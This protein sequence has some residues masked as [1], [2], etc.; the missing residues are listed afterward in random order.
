MLVLE[1]VHAQ[2]LFLLCQLASLVTHLFALAALGRHAGRLFVDGT[3]TFGC[4]AG[5]H[6]RRLQFDLS[7]ILGTV[8]RHRFAEM[9][10]SITVGPGVRL[11]GERRTGQ[12][13]KAED[14]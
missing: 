6:R 1:L 5:D 12:Q 2:L 9:G 4:G 3:K 7:G 11:S 8:G 10:H 14:G 13:D